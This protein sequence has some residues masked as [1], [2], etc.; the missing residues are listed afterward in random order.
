MQM[1]PTLLLKKKN[2]EEFQEGDSRALGQAGDPCKQRS[3]THEVTL[4]WGP[5]KVS[6]G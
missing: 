2:Y 5:E 6:K 4:K 1:K 3:H